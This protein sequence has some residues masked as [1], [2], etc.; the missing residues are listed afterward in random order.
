MNERPT[1]FELLRDF[2]RKGDQ[3]AFATAV[4]RHLDLVYA[5]ALR[6]AEDGG[7]AEEISQNVFAAL[8]RK[9]WQFGSDD[10]L[11]AWLHRATLLE[12]REWLRGDLRR[13][14]R[15][16]AAAELGTTMKTP[17]E[18]TA[19]RALVPLLDE[20]LLSL[21]EKDRA[22]LLL[23]FYESRSLRDVG[24]SLGI[25][26]DAAQKRVDSALGRL[27]LFFQ[28]RGFRTATIA[29]ATAALQHTAA[30]APAA[31]A[32]SI[33]QT[34]TQLA[35]PAAGLTAL[36]S[37]LAGF[38][39]VQ[40]A[41]LC[42][43]IVAV[44]SA[45]QWNTWQTAKSQA[46]RAQAQREVRR[47]E[48]ETVRADIERLR[49]ESARLSNNQAQWSDD[50]ARNEAAQS[51]LVLLKDR[52]RRLLAVSDS[53]WPDDLPFVRI[54]NWIL[55]NLNPQYPTF[56][57]SGR[58]AQWVKEILN[59]SPDQTQGIERN[60]AQ[61]LEEL[62]NL[63][64]SRAYETNSEVAFSKGFVTKSVAVP[65]LGDDGA[66][67][68]NNLVTNLQAVLNN[69]DATA[70]VLS[71]LSSANQ[72]VSLERMGDELNR[73]TQQFTLGLNLEDPN[74]P[75]FGFTWHGHI[76]QSGSRTIPIRMPDFL[77]E[78]FD[79]WLRGFGVTNDVFKLP[80][81]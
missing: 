48:L 56:N 18:Q 30:S 52:L 1:D 64:G 47:T 68:K 81:S 71:P 35:P 50:Q 67:L 65:A 76:G 70:L 25:G 24:A 69:P 78:H 12:A 14:R 53:R 49:I 80:S 66:L 29:A 27:S 61:Y 73:S 7:A 40:T 72:W 58:L 45:W 28:R 37:R 75:R 6:K 15:E 74:D 59:L 16:Q 79:P 34:V 21:R 44:P 51:K 36:L 8:A 43:V 9:A 23:R 5:T 32:A 20:A 4:R 60:L 19:L 55:T 77:R 31:A 22:A 13:Q 41:A 46:A 62:N 63:A 38:G 54:P 26:E 33:T 57:A 39:K 42:V 10:S 17:E 11:P 2:A 3:A